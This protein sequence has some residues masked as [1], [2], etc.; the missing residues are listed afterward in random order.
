MRSATLRYAFTLCGESPSASHIAATGTRRRTLA[1][2]MSCACLNLAA[3]SSVSFRP[4]S[5][6]NCA[7]ISRKAGA[8]VATWDGTAVIIGCSIVGAGSTT[9]Q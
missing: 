3:A 7:Q 5:A 2:R 8:T 4:S 9:T 1:S 6:R